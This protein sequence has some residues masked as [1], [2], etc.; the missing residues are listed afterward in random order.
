M[1]TR[2]TEKNRNETKIR[3]PNYKMFD[4]KV[5]G[6]I[7]DHDPHW[8]DNGKKLQLRIDVTQFRIDAI[9]GQGHGIEKKGHEGKDQGQHHV[10]AKKGQGDK[11]QGQMT[12]VQNIELKGQVQCHEGMVQCR[13]ET[14]TVLGHLEEVNIRNASQVRVPNGNECQGDSNW[15]LHEVFYQPELGLIKGYVLSI[16]FYF[17]ARFDFRNC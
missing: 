12:K 15:N 10:I 5:T 14:G 4:R 6:D 13:I 1:I 7:R 17:E 9:L 11:G 16:A 3:S 2:K 8:T